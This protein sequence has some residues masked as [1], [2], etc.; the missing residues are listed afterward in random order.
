MIYKGA[1]TQYFDNYSPIYLQKK[2]EIDILG[3][4]VCIKTFSFNVAYGYNMK[5][6]V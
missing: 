1:N 2:S 5:V 6:K 4:L 3:C